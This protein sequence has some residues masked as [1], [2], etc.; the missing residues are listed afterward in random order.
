[1]IWTMNIRLGKQTFYGESLTNHFVSDISED[2][3][4]QG[5]VSQVYISL[6]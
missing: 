5:E 4:D 3:W 2:V 6:S 1:M